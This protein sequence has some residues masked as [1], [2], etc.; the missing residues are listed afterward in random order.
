M[1]SVRTPLIADGSKQNDVVY[2]DL[3]GRQRWMTHRR[4]IDADAFANTVEAASSA[5]HTS[6]P[7]REGDRQGQ[8]RN[9]P[10]G[11]EVRHEH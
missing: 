9:L 11:A 1:A 5:A 10:D 8:R 6:T 2:R 4:K 3:N 7:M